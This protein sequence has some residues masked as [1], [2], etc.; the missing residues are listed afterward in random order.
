[1]LE[2]PH[3]LDPA[4][5][6]L[7]GKNGPEPGLPEPHRLMRDVDSALVQKVLDVPQRQRVADIHHH[8]QADDLR[9]GVE[10]AENARVALPIRLATLPASG[11]PIF[12]LTV[13]SR[14]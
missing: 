11:N 1:M 7:G 6:E 12:P 4:A 13:P 3:R 14:A 5:P 9:A 2:R 8:S 10:F